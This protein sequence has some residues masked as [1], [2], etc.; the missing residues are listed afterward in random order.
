MK[1]QAKN[2]GIALFLAVIAYSF[3]QGAIS[4][5]HKV[6]IWDLVDSDDTMRVLQVRAWLDGQGFYDLL[7]HRSNPPFGASMHWSRLADL[8]LALLQIL[9]RPLFGNVQAEHI[10]VFAVPPMLGLI[11]VWLLGLAAKHL[12][13]TWFS[14]F[15]A[16]VLFTFSV[17]ATYN[18]V[19]GRVDHHGL[20]LICF[21]AFLLG[22]VQNTV[23][24]GV[25]AGISLGASLTIGFEMLPLQILAVT[26][27]ALIW[28]LAGAARKDQVIGFCMAFAI[29]TLFGFFLNVA[30]NAY[31]AQTNDALSIAQLVTIFVGALGFGITAQ[32][33]SERS[34][35]LRFLTLGLIA[36]LVVLCALQFQEL[37]KPLYW[38]TSE[39]LRTK[40]LLTNGEVIPMMQ[41]PILDQLAVGVMLLLALPVVF[42]Q[43]FSHKAR[44]AEWWLLAI[45]LLGASGLAFFYQTR[46]HFQATT[47]AILVL[48][49]VLPK[50]LSPK[51]SAI[52]LAVMA[53]AAP[54]AHTKL[55]QAANEKIGHNNAKYA[56]NGVKKCHT[57]RDFAALSAQPK[58]LLTT[59]LDLGA[60]ALITTP[61]DVLGTAYHRDFGKE[62]MYHILISKPVI[63]QTQIR[64]HSVDYLAYCA[65][66]V[67]IDAIAEFAPNG[68]MA[69]LLAGKIPAYLQP[70][71][72]Q[73]DSHIVAFKVARAVD[74]QLERQ[75]GSN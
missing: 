41:R 4:H 19:P 22:L 44:N 63:A 57:T 73:N 25:I 13:G 71:P 75:L 34:F 58:G 64:A 27:L 23:K 45:L 39:I 1:N 33:T 12:S 49:A 70:I 60:L 53:I 40:W 30:P 14:P 46:F 38:Q 59:N 65:S 43:I 20:Q 18:F 61:H 35:R 54:F 74:V 15:F 66:D 9:L 47:I 62:Y 72:N 2:I 21:A 52:A 24:G 69:Q 36:I 5:W 48:A 29:A 51:S 6:L 67:D 31:F 16:I 26:W 7:N 50:I 17:S 55:K 28:G 42:V 37:F 3:L 10:A 11:Y 68:L 8:P 32:K 56:F